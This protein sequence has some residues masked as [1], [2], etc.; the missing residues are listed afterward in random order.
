MAKQTYLERIQER[1]K[2]NPI[3][4]WAI[5]IATIVI[6]LAALLPAARQ[7]LEETGLRG[8]EPPPLNI[9]LEPLDPR[10]IATGE[11]S[12]TRRIETPLSRRVAQGSEEIM[13]WGGGSQSL[14][15]ELQENLALPLF[16]EEKGAGHVPEA[17]AFFERSIRNGK[18]MRIWEV[19]GD[20]AD[21]LNGLQFYMNVTYDA[22]KE[23]PIAVVKE[24]GVSVRIIALPQNGSVLRYRTGGADISRTAALVRIEG[25]KRFNPMTA[26]VG[27]S[28]KS[29]EHLVTYLEPGEPSFL[30]ISAAYDDRIQPGSGAAPQAFEL[31]GYARIVVAGKPYLI[32]S[33]NALYAIYSPSS[34][35]HLDRMADN[36]LLENLRPLAFLPR[37]EVPVSEIKRALDDA[38][39]QRQV[40]AARDA[41]QGSTVQQGEIEDQSGGPAPPPARTSRTFWVQLGAFKEQ[42]RARQLA[43]NVT[44]AGF[45]SFV[46]E[47]AGSDGQPI[48]RVRLS[49]SS[50]TR[51]D[52]ARLVDLVKERMPELKPVVFAGD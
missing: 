4:A 42:A 7:L 13:N 48:Y 11:S 45:A 32:E 39:K 47:K 24:W 28:E 21:M 36:N 29:P 10:W 17:G 15:L 40:I 30:L 2:N 37:S 35:P 6:S 25:D 27:D 3:I 51:E 41:A 16:R 22:Q 43:D 50:M 5:L 8:D 9:T 19:L 46:A 44:G 52:A 33:R 23:A 14:F 12:Q 31:K 49:Q 20:H 38:E 18:V 1:L 26:W 34:D